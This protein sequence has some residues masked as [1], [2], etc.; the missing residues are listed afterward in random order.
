MASNALTISNFQAGLADSP[1]EGFAR[2]NNIELFEKPGVA[3][4]QFGASLSFS[5]TSL[6][7]KMVYDSL[8]NQYVGCR[9]GEF[10]VN[11]VL[12]ATAT[13]GIC[14]MEVVN[15]F[16]NEYTVSGITG[17]SVNPTAGAI[18]ST[19]GNNYKVTSVSITA[20]S[21]S[22]II[23]GTVT[24]GGAGTLT[25]VSGT[26]DASI[27]WSGTVNGNTNL[28]YVMVT[29][30][31]YHLGFYGPT[32]SGGASFV[33][34]NSTLSGTYHRDIEVG[35]DITNSR[36]NF[37]YIGNGPY[38][39]SIQAIVPSAI[40]VAPTY[41]LNTSALTVQPGFL[42]YTLG[43]LGKY[44]TVGCTLLG[45]NLYDNVNL[46]GSAFILWDRTSPTFNIPVF[47]K[48]NGITQSLQLQN[49]IFLG[50]GN[51]GRYFVSD[52]VNYSQIKRIPFSWNRQ[53]GNYAFLYPNALTLHNGE[54]LMG[55]SGD[56]AGNTENNYGVYGINLDKMSE[57]VYPAFLRNTPSTGGT[58]TL[59]T[60]NIGFLHSTSADV[61]Y[62]GW[63]DGSTY[64]VDVVTSTIGTAYPQLTAVI[65][66]PF[67]TV[68]TELIK[69]TYKTAELSLTQ[70]L[71]GTQQIKISYRE[72]LNIDSWTLIRDIRNNKDYFDASNFGANNNYNFSANLASKTKLQFK[73]EMSQDTVDSPNNIELISLTFF[74]SEK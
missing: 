31:D 61:L 15:T 74:P 4:I 44:L 72:N 56:G 9:G 32:Y 70:P 46:K 18:Y 13:T 47:F 25:K 37:I 65:Y 20:G 52:G 67:Y 14:D 62:I 51:R 42:A 3:K 21:G 12:N 50:I 11:G 17:V 69:K 29:E 55:V 10:Y 60:L 71:T 34:S 63:Q 36:T 38:V 48:E 73:I 41:S 64:G 26:G 54:L 24:P 30:Q 5:T 16:Y 1:I 35:I 6:P 33:E 66:S 22:M 8:G 39:A 28:E 23:V 68:G 49:R 59:Q 27:T 53:F 7:M 45:V 2:L 19:G 40:G 43:T 57:N 58:G